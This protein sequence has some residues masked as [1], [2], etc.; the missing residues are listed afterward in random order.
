VDRK[1]DVT[2]RHLEPTDIA[3][4]VDRA[5]RDDEL[6]R[7]ESHL[8]TCRE[9]RD[10]V[11]DAARIVAT[12]PRAR[13]MR[14]RTW[15]SA[16]AIA[17]VLLLVVWPRTARDPGLQH[18]GGDATAIAG[19]PVAL[20]PKGLVDSATTLVWSSV[21]SADRYEARIFDAN[22]TVL[23]QRETTDTTA[24]MPASIDLQPGRSYFWKVEARTG[25]DR[26][27]SSD[28]VEFSVRRSRRP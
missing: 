1:S 16:A 11:S 14:S 12:L 6:A 15:I 20:A 19:V 4:Y 25:F 13:G 28:L 18:R 8:A 23:W 26:A 27:A 2:E 7:I 3:S 22:G 5:A 21:T 24:V 9:C 17:A 10:E